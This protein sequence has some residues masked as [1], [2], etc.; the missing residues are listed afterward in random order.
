MPSITAPSA[1]FSG[2][3]FEHDDHVFQPLQFVQFGFFFWGEKSGLIQCQQT[4]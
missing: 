2:A 4:A 1:H 3:D